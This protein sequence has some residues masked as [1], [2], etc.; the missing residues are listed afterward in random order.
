MPFMFPAS[1]A[2]AAMQAIRARLD[3]HADTIGRM[4]I[5]IGLLVGSYAP[6]LFNLDLLRR[7]KRA[8]DPDGV[9]SPGAYDL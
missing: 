4:G 7:L 5:E 2:L 9:L 8:V 6:A 3:S 1:A